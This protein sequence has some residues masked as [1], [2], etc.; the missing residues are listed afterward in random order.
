MP[1]T[2]HEAVTVGCTYACI[3]S[4]EQRQPPQASNL[5][6][7]HELRIAPLRAPALHIG[8]NDF[9][10]KQ[11]DSYDSCR[12]PGADL[13][14]SQS[15]HSLD[16]ARIMHIQSIRDWPRCNN[17]KLRPYLHSAMSKQTQRAPNACDQLLLPWPDPSSKLLVLTRAGNASALYSIGLHSHNGSSTCTTTALFTNHS[18]SSSVILL[19]PMPLSH[20]FVLMTNLVRHV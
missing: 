10:Q 2:Q 14:S 3:L 8:T 12:T 15:I 5:S 7:F 1:L 18:L 16:E 4:D 9:Q 11:R 17:D 13:P 20:V 6:G 19:H